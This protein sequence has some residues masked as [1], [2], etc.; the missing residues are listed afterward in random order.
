M[1]ELTHF[2]SDG[3]SQMVD[4]GGK[5]FSLRTAVASGIVRMKV[6]TQN[7]IRAAQI[8]KGDVLGIARI[9]AIMATK[10]TSDLIPLC[11]P[12]SLNSVTVDFSFPTDSLI[13]IEV[14]VSATE[15][16]GVE[17]E[18]LMAVSVAGLTI[19]DMCKSCDKEMAIAEIRL[20]K[21]TG[22]KSGS[23]SRS[24]ESSNQRTND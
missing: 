8:E 17:M 5:Q 2:D 20:E 23:F 10:R 3:R 18:A 12:L 16:T 21:K 9:A 1:P 15:R 7:L 4:V 11:H 6:Q 14:T 19:Y 13:Q 24:P 22:G